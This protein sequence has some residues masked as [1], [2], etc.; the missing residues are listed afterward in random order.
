MF[1]LIRKAFIP[2]YVWREEMQ[3]I[4]SVAGETMNRVVAASLLYVST[5]E[6]EC[7]KCSMIGNL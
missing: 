6:Q 2:V 3:K 5:E 7:S 1:S 4:E